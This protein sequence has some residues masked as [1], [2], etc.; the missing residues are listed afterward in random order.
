M[1]AVDSWKLPITVAINH[2][3]RCLNLTYTLLF[4]VSTLP[5]RR[6]PLAVV[7]EPCLSRKTL[8]ITNGKIIQQK[9]FGNVKLYEILRCLST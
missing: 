8:T 1:R 6:T 3:L 4:R 5:A 2:V 7:F 9:D